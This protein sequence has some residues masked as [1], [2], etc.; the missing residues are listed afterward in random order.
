MASVTI[1][2]T[3]V[4]PGGGHLRFAIS[5]AASGSIHSMLTDLTDAVTE[6]EVE[7]FIKVVSKLARSGRTL[8]Q[9][10]TLLQAGVTV[11][12]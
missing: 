1:T 8:A 12:V 11:T 10:K 4:C 6:P 3:S 9:A 2:L 5:G 7:A